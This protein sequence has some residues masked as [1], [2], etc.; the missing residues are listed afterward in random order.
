M[1]IHWLGRILVMACGLAV[2]GQGQSISRVWVIPETPVRGQAMQFVVTGVTMT[3]NG[4]SVT[5]AVEARTLLVHFLRE[6]LGL[7]RAPEFEAWL[8]RMQITDDAGQLRPPSPNALLGGMG[9]LKSL[10][11]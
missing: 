8:Q 3:V 4:K 9:H 7:K 10:V 11:A 5:G 6:T 1:M 2:L